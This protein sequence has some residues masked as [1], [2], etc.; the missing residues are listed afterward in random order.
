MKTREKELNK[1]AYLMER[2]TALLN[3]A[4]D[5]QERVDTKLEYNLTIA[6]PNGFRPFTDEQIDTCV[7]GRDRLYYSFEKT[8]MEILNSER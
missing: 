6:E 1:K 5:M 8:L 3:A 7:R 2:A 4:R